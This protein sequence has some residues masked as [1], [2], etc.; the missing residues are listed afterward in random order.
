MHFYQLT[1]EMTSD[2]V[3]AVEDLVVFTAKIFHGWL[4]DT[5]DFIQLLAKKFHFIEYN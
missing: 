1:W 3:A 4:Q 2:L 5:R